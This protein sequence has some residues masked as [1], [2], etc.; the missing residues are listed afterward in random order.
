MS[1]R[2]R[3]FLAGCQAAALVAGIAG[4]DGAEDPAAEGPGRDA[5]AGNSATADVRR[6]DAAHLCLWLPR[7]ALERILDRNRIIG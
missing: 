4:C 1:P 5:V 7:H 3:A 6:Q 2:A